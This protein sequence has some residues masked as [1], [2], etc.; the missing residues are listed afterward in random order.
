[1]NHPPTHDIRLLPPDEAQ[2]RVAEMLRRLSPVLEAAC[3]DFVRGL[4]TEGGGRV[5]Y[6]L[7]YGAAVQALLGVAATYAVDVGMGPEVLAGMVRELCARA[8]AKAP[9][10]G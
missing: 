7:A 10:F 6:R 1:M 2:R 3:A 5:D 8:A 4:R 9:R